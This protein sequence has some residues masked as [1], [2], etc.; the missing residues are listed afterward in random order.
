M[1]VPS[2]ADARDRNGVHLSVVIWSHTRPRPWFTREYESGTWRF[3]LPDDHLTS[4]PT[5][6]QAQA[7]CWRE[8]WTLTPNLHPV[9]TIWREPRTMF[10]P[11]SPHEGCLRFS[12]RKRC[13]V[14]ERGPGV[15]LKLGNLLWLSLDDTSATFGWPEIPPIFQA[16]FHFCRMTTG[17]PYQ[18]HRLTSLLPEIPF[19]CRHSLPFPFKWTFAIFRQNPLHA[20]ESVRFP[21]LSGRRD[22]YPV[23]HH[24]DETLSGRSNRS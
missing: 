22:C 1:Y 6:L 19:F 7:S 9:A 12:L 24:P 23:L 2:S 16:M 3:G 4:T 10:R 13:L 8:R 18:W 11:K 17:Q 15:P 5:I 20:S 21:M 14:P